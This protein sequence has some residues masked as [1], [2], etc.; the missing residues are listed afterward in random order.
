VKPQ[1]E[2]EFSFSL[3]AICTDE[4][5]R[6]MTGATPAGGVYSGEGISHGVLFPADAAPGVHVLTYTYTDNEGC[7]GSDTAL[8][9]IEICSAIP[10]AR[11]MGFQVSP[12]PFR[13]VLMVKFTGK[14]DAEKVIVYDALGKEITSV[15]VP[16]SAGESR[17][18][19]PASAPAG[20]LFLKV[21]P[22]NGAPGEVRKVVKTL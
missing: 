18:Q 4:A 13:D 19:L 3:N 7:A 21:I 14:H 22:K 17:I 2:V 9:R 11:Q 20:I 1:P 12:N 10:N 15:L 8:M 16:P 5:S 6:A